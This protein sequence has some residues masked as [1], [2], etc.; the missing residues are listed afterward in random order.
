PLPLLPVFRPHLRRLIPVDA[1]NFVTPVKTAD[2]NHRREQ[3]TR[4]KFFVNKPGYGCT[5]GGRKIQAIASALSRVDAVSGADD[6]YEQSR[7][8]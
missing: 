4:Q 5:C 8:A 1:V 3:T 2:V 6:N 7:Y